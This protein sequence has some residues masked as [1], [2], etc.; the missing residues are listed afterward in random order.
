LIQ[1]K[2]Q[3]PFWDLD[4]GILFSPEEGIAAVADRWDPR[5]VGCVRGKPCAAA[6]PIV[7]D[8][9]KDGITLQHLCLREER[10][11][12]LGVGGRRKNELRTGDGKGRVVAYPG[13]SLAE[14]TDSRRSEDAGRDTGATVL[15]RT[16]GSRGSD[17]AC[18]RWR[19]G[20]WRRTASPREV[21]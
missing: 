16:R 4:L 12:R 15:R 11:Q 17:R 18:A 3:G 19:R 5:H 14:Q 8:E 6:V 21:P 2:I 13:R 10:R 1:E 20:V 9:T 7:S